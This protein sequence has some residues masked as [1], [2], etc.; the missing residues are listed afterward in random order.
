MIVVCMR[1]DRM[2]PTAKL[3]WGIL[4]VAAINQRILPSFPRARNAELRAI[5]SRSLDRAKAAAQAAGIPVAHG[6]YEALLDDPTID[7]VYNPLPN[8]LHAEWSRKAAERG[9]HVWCEKPLCPTAAEAHA[10]LDFCESKGVKLM[11]GFMWPHHPRTQQ[12]RRFLDSGGIGEVRR[13]SGA[14]TFPMEPLDPNNI[15]LKPELGGGSLLD[16]GCYPVYGIRW[17]LGIE[18]LEVM[19]KARYY[20]GVDIEMN[21]ILTFADG[22][23]AAFDCGFTLPYR[24]WLEILGT[25]GTVRIPRMWVPPPK[26]T[27]Y[28]H[29]EDKA[30]EEVSIDGEDQIQHMIENFSRAVLENEPVTPSPDEAVKTLRV[31]DALAQSARE[32][33]A[34]EV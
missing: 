29:R 10:L 20:N 13:V 7:A 23:M 4:G 8:S 21:G 30:G 5:A 16:V 11:E 12:I 15:R 19:A 28:I 32:G 18:P 14:F 3:R 22:R 24:G 2:P 31:L 6:S 26:A 9:K 34:V 1:G 17:V 25:E 33:R 27:F